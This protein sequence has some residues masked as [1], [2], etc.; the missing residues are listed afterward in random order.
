M[1]VLLALQLLAL[2][3]S[4]LL[5]LV[6]PPLFMTL[7]DRWSPL[8]GALWVA[9][10]VLLAVWVEA[11]YRAGAHADETRSTGNVFD[12][13]EWLTAAVVAAAASALVTLTPG[14]NGAPGRL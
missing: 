1:E 13:V 10:L 2:P 7:R 11:S 14:R 4:A 9:A 5:A 8:A 12:T 3:V 6:A